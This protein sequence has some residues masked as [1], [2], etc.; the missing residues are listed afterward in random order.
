MK[1]ARQASHTSN[2]A[3]RETPTP[4][5]HLAER[6][7]S[8]IGSEHAGTN[9]YRPPNDLRTRVIVFEAFPDGRLPNRH[10]A[11]DRAHTKIEEGSDAY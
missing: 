10:E 2:P 7:K 8:E 3:L 11:L 1:R 5:L 9:R 4:Y 6:I